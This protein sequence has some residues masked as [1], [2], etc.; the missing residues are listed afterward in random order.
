MRIVLA[1]DLTALGRGGLEAL[2]RELACGLSENH[3]IILAAADNPEDIAQ[4]SLASHLLDFIQTP[5]G[6]PPPEW[7]RDFA[8]DLRR[9]QVDLCHF[10]LAG[11]YGWK[12]GSREFSPILRVS[13]QGIRCL[14]TNH[15][16]IHPFD[17]SRA[18][19]PVWRRLGFHLRTI[20]GK[21][22]CLRA[23]EREY[24]VS[25]H[26]LRIARATFPMFWH[27][28]GRIYHSCL[29]SNPPPLDLPESRVILNLATV[30]FRKGQHV[31]AEAFA[32][33]ARN[34][35][36]WKLRFVGIKAQK[37]C[38]EAIRQIARSNGMEDR[39]ELCGPTADPVAA[40]RESEIYVQPSL[41]E[42]LG[43]S[44]QE[45]MFHGR[46]CIGSKV[47][48]IPELIDHGQNGLLV[49]PNDSDKLADTL[50]LLMG[51]RARRER[52]AAE[53][54]SAIPAKGMTKAAML[55]AYGKLY[56]QPPEA[57]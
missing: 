22:S 51:E 50:S 57:R 14:A 10:H 45:A 36:E 9:R 17:L 49:P 34:H 6:K 11:T 43:L 26:D 8:S 23:I 29:G 13:S 41:L 4:S 32:R 56:A 40:I 31:L 53:A 24:L 42:G 52:F 30:C 33:I 25:D 27:K 16:A 28:F 21:W 1:T 54:R 20:P 12:S 15:Q 35:P 47:G 5:K 2:I 38:V 44:L 37:E 46:P 18:G 55:D 19:D 3:Q 7:S 48:G 39:I